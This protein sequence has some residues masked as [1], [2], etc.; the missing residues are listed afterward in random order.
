MLLLLQ[1][2]WLVALLTHFAV[3]VCYLGPG[4]AVYRKRLH[5]NRVVGFVA[6]SA[7]ALRCLTLGFWFAALLFISLANDSLPI[8]HTS[9]YISLALVPALILCAMGTLWSFWLDWSHDAENH[10]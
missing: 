5:P 1:A 7:T 8:S 3:A 9:M 6:A 2:L 10:D 4:V